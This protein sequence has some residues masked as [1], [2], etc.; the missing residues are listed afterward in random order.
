LLFAVAFTIEGRG[1][2]VRDYRRGIHNNR[3][4]RM[5]P[6]FPLWHSITVLL[7][8]FLF[9]SS[10]THQQH[11]VFSK[12]EDFPMEEG[13]L[14]THFL[15]HTDSEKCSQDIHDAWS[16]ESHDF[17]LRELVALEG[18]FMRDTF[19]TGGTGGKR[20]EKDPSGECVA[21]CLQKGT[22]HN[23]LQH[24]LPDN[25]FT[26]KETENSA[27][28][29]DTIITGIIDWIESSCQ[30]AELGIVNYH[31][32]EATVFWLN[33]HSGEKVNVGH[34][35]IGERNTLWQVTV[36]GHVFEVVSLSGV[37]LGSFEVKHNSFEVVGDAGSRV[38]RRNVTEEVRR[39]LDAEWHRS[40]R[41]KR[42]FTELGFDKGR[43]PE[44]LWSSMATYYWNNRHNKVREEWDMKGLYV[45]HWEVDPYMIAMPWNLKRYW[46]SRLK[47]VVE[48]WAGVDL[49]LTD[50]YG[51]RRYEDGA[52]LLTHVDREQTHAASLIIN[53]AQKNI[54]E[55]WKVEIYD[56]ADRLH[57]IIMDEGDIVYYESARCLHGRNKPLLGDFYVNLFVHYRPIDDPMW[58]T[59]ESPPGTPKPVIDLASSNVAVPFLNPTERLSGYEDLFNWWL[60]TSPPPKDGDE[61]LP[62]LDEEDINSNSYADDDYNQ[63]GEESAHEE[64]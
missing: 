11:H 35:S 51:M 63:D 30:R 1:F 29:D 31:N 48:A 44:D 9:V 4:G 53:I 24:F 38:F 46:Q 34:L 58:F 64:L 19:L 56:H 33:P 8:L 47:P 43:L 57:E 23:M 60:K 14:S 5:G 42:T 52:R 12:I 21:I 49:E 40:R 62:H 41:V 61:F 45:N 27:E 17:F 2:T 16:S 32:E 13:H 18:K 25:I 28:T 10:Q 36:L 26:W 7:L 37:H 3:A 54:R 59:R 15:L 39:T 50:M 22:A 20:I 55:H 6:P